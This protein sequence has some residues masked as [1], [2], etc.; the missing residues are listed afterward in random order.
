M[1]QN[2]SEEMNEATAPVNLTSQE[3]ISDLSMAASLTQA[4]RSANPGFVKGF[5]LDI[6]T[7]KALLAQNGSDVSGIRIYLGVDANKANVAVAVSTVGDNFDDFGIPSSVGED[8][9]SL[10]G[11]ARPCPSQCGKDNALNSDYSTVR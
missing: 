7:I 4:H 5:V 8:C 10:I 2:F 9:K 1:D 11:E 3:E 6:K